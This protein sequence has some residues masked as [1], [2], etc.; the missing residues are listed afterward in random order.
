[1]R[2][3][4]A[5]LSVSS[6]L[7]YCCRCHALLKLASGITLHLAMF[8]TVAASVLEAKLAVLWLMLYHKRDFNTPMD[9]A[10]VDIEVPQSRVFL[11]ARHEFEL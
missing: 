4:R 9:L 3:K 10:P 8:A 7:L 5:S 2:Y 11:L 6:L 1:M